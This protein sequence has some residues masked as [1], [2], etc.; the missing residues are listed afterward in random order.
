MEWVA[1]QNIKDLQSNNN[2]SMHSW[3]YNI[4]VPAER[5]K[6]GKSNSDTRW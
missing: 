5:S 6:A 4:Y 1:G 2:T 3:P